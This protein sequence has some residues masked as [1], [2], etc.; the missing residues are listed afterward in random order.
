MKSS[1]GRSTTTELGWNPPVVVSQVDVG[2][3]SSVGRTWECC[4]GSAAREVRRGVVGGL[5]SVE[6][7]EG[8]PYHE[9]RL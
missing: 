7:P 3:G 6:S 1:Y 8:R 5:T 2:G 9:L 4:G